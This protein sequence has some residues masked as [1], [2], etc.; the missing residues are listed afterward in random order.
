MKIH[1]D[2]ALSFFTPTADEVQPHRLRTASVPD[3]FA[4]AIDAAEATGEWQ[5]VSGWVS[6]EDAVRTVNICRR[7]LYRHRPDIK[8]RTRTI[9]R[10]D[11][12][13]VLLK[14]ILRD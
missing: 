8:M 10:T 14:I 3:A 7:V 13:A 6:K 11:S 12:W 4:A 1:K 9:Q 2:A 5:G